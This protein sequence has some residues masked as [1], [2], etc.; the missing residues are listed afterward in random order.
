MGANTKRYAVDIIRLKFY[1]INNKK[2]PHFV[3][4][5]VDGTTQSVVR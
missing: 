3:H 2:K 5:L 1:K 4:D